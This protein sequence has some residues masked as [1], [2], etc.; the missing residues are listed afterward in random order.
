MTYKIIGD[1][2]LD[3]RK[4]DKKDEHFQII[5]LTLQVEDRQF[6]DDD[7]FSQKD[8][9]KAVAASP[10]CPKSACPSPN[11]FLEA[12][13][14]AKVDMIFVITLSSKLSGSYNSAE[15]ARNMYEEESGCDGKKIAVI[16]SDSASVGESLIAFN[17]QKMAQKGADFDTI[18]K[19]T[20]LFVKTMKTYF[21]LESL[22]TLRKNGRLTGIKAFFA[23]ALNIKPVMGANSGEIIKLDQ[24]RGI[25]KALSKMTDILIKEVPDSRTKT[26]AIAHCNCPARAEYVKELLLQKGTFKD[27][28]IADT[29]GVS[30]MYA[31]DGGI[32]VC[33]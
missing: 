29:A 31:S 6:I 4:E 30:T 11:T 22:E 12:Y 10:Q 2:C 28:Y 25:N 5:P 27:V 24:A 13:R 1:S 16:S 33:C 19:N 20:A 9:L 3:L 23:S 15:V 14:A 18:M 17:I 32:I 7:S 8:F 21:V 26:V